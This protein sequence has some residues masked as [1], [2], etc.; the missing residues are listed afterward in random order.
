[1]AI[2]IHWKSSK[3]PQR[4]EET[5]SLLPSWDDIASTC[6]MESEATAESPQRSDTSK[7][8]V[9]FNDNIQTHSQED[10]NLRQKAWRKKRGIFVRCIH[11][12]SKWLLPCM[13]SEIL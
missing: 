3:L 13:H 2:G 6:S 4:K 12:I 8:T 11:K 1:M 5:E 10:W 9:S 7:K